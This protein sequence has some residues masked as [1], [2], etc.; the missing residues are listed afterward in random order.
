MTFWIA[1]NLDLENGILTS[2]LPVLIFATATWDNPGKLMRV[3]I[4][5]IEKKYDYKIVVC[6]MD[7]DNAADMANKL[8]INTVPTVRIFKDGVKVTEFDGNKSEAFLSK[9]IEKIL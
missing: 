3:A 7:I 9:A 8:G 6:I 5:K 2:K 4:D 1:E